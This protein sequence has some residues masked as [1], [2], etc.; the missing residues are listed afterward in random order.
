MEG[1]TRSRPQHARRLDQPWSRS[2]PEPMDYGGRRCTRF[3]SARNRAGR[4][5]HSALRCPIG[6]CRMRD[7]HFRGGGVRALQ[8]SELRLPYRY[9]K[10]AG[11]SPGTVRFA[12]G[13]DSLGAAKKFHCLIATVRR[14]VGKASSGSRT[15]SGARTG[16]CSVVLW[17]ISGTLREGGQGC[18][19]VDPA[20]VYRA[21][22]S[23]RGPR[24]VA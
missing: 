5:A 21:R 4:M 1:T 7:F 10:C 12:T 18:T 6:R 19:A 22:P 15:Y 24:P 23:F 14:P 13:A 16:M 8:S 11:G 9:E 3:R 2:A 20:H 17:A